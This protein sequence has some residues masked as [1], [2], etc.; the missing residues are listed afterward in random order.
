MLYVTAGR[1]RACLADDSRI[2]LRPHLA[3]TLLKGELLDVETAGDGALEL[4]VVEL[5]AAG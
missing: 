4:Y 3:L 1:G 5:G 2:D